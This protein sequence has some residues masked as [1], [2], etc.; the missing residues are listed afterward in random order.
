[1]KNF[2]FYLKLG[3]VLMIFCIIAAASLAFTYSITEPIVKERETKEKI[4]KY[5][6]VLAMFE[7]EGAAPEEDLEGL[8]EGK[9][10]AD[11]LLMVYRIVSGE[12][13]VGMAIET[14][15]SG[16]GGPVKIAVAIRP[17]GSIAGVKILDVSGETKGVGSRVLE[18]PSF[19]AQFPGKTVEDPLKLK[20][21]IDVISGASLS[22][23][24]VA[25]GV[26]DAAQVFKAISG[27][28]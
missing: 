4:E 12:E 7:V 8:E 23:G 3:A 24:A 17:D 9:A 16:Y 6:D 26:S 25:K 19:V 20:T 14:G 28:N 18:D 2:L 11:S 22:S 27:G 5:K 15:A 13:E 1:M 10:I 21:D